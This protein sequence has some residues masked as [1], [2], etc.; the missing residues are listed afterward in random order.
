[1]K[2]PSLEFLPIELVIKI[3]GLLPLNELLLKARLV[4]RMCNL[5][6]R[7]QLASW[8]L[9][10]RHAVSGAIQILYNDRPI[11]VYQG[12][13]FT[14]S[15]EVKV[16]QQETLSL[17]FGAHK[18]NTL[19]NIT[20]EDFRVINL[21]ELYLAAG[22][23]GSTMKELVKYEANP[24]LWIR[25]EQPLSESKPRNDT[26]SLKLGR[27]IWLDGD[28]SLNLTSLFKGRF[29]FTLDFEGKFERWKY[30]YI[31]RGYSATVKIA[32]VICDHDEET[33]AGDHNK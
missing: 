27:C 26:Q 3:L 8:T 22:F 10:L 12:D 19:P 24:K 7:A 2:P 29:E 14:L 28:K 32:P 5:L 23:C 33:Q 17:S 18:S 25:F 11:I 4:N 1:M 9:S 31:F 20:P 30:M 15:N 16:S 21:V 13:N 6:L